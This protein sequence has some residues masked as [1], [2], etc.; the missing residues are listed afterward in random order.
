MKNIRNF[1]IIAHIDHGK[2]TLADR[3]LEL[4]GTIEKRKMREQVLDSMDLERERGITIKLQ[5]ARMK[6]GAAGAEF[7]LNLIDTPGHV[8]FTY[9][10]SRSLAAVEGVLLLV[11]ATKGVQAQTIANLYLALEENLVI[12]PVINK[13]DMEGAMIGETEKEFSRLLGVS[14]EEIIKISAK[15]G[16]NVNAVLEAIVAKIPPPSGDPK[17]DARA[18]IFAS[19]HDPYLGIVAHIRVRDGEIKKGDALKFI[20]TGAVGEVKEI[21]Y[22]KPEPVPV[23]G[24][25]SG[26]IGYIATG[27]KDTEMC[28]VGDT[29][30]LLGAAAK[31]L[32]GYKEPRPVV[33]ASFYPQEEARYDTLRDALA[34]LK[35]TDAALFYE[36]ESS[37]ALGRG[38]RCGF[39]GML[40]LEI[41]SE[42]LKREFNLNVVIT[43][44]SVSYEVMKKNGEIAKIF[45]P[46]SLPP[47]GEINEIREPWVRLE[48][49]TP[50]EYL[51]EA[52][53]LA[54]KLRGLYKNTQYLSESR[55]ILTY[56]V[57]LAEIIVDFHDNLKSATKGYASMSYEPLDWRPGDLARLDVFVAGEKVDAFSRIIPRGRAQGEGRALVEK[58]KELL[59]RQWFAVALQASIGGKIIARE[60]ISAFRKDVTGYLYGGDVT[61]KKKLLE[62]QKKGKKKMKEIGRVNIPQDVF[63]RVLKER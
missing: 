56:E 38:F 47:A 43:L 17:G 25:K 32:S 51:G 26:E 30:A 23:S 57:P 1:S 40:H 45:S 18:L 41:I 59:P 20:A 49:L 24:L 31:P 19:H 46:Q 2:S 50:A 13:I 62:K 55:A 54:E 42:R 8:D 39:L 37:E 48:I 36:P 3:L 61:R 9:E 21:G 14:P 22:F 53:K 11:D 6:Y 63:L 5:P 33:F 35:L 52:M 10:V 58:L 28:R 44:P 12:I 7:I 15:N 60:T 34:K 29:V 4:T 16:T 27:L